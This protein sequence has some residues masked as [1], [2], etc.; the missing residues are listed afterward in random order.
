MTDQ[1]KTTRQM[2]IDATL[3]NAERSSKHH[4]KPNKLALA[5]AHLT[6]FITNLSASPT[7]TKHISQPPF[8]PSTLPPSQ[9]KPL[10]KSRSRQLQSTLIHSFT[11]H[12]AN[13]PSYSP[14]PIMPTQPARSLH[15]KHDRKTKTA[16]TFT[17]AGYAEVYALKIVA[18][19]G[20]SSRSRYPSRAVKPNHDVE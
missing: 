3:G 20:C 2:T 16:A 13:K 19:E 11:H 7:N 8:H 18:E 10:A 5:P 17:A 4:S 1:A 9:H 6:P 15:T 14:P 12:T